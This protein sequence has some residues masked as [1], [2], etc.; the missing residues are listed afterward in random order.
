MEAVVES[1]GE[2]IGISAPG[3]NIAFLATRGIRHVPLP[4]STRGAS[5]RSD[6]RA[7]WDLRRILRN[8]KP[9]VLHT[10]NPKPGIYG[11]IVGRLSG[12]PIVVNTVH[13]LYATPDD[14]LLK[15]A[16]IYALEAIASRFSD[17]ELVQNPEDLQLITGLRIS[18]PSK[19]R[20]LGNGVDLT[21]FQAP[22][23][24]VRA[25]VRAELGLAPGDI[26]VGFVGRLVEEKGLVEL[27][28]AM[29]SLEKRFV[30]HVVGPTD[31]EKADSLPEDFITE[32]K[33]D[34]TRF[35][36]MRTDVE[37][38]Y[39]GFDIFVL[40]SHREGF[41]RTAMEAA[42]SALP[43]V[44][45][46]IRG[47]RQ[48]VEDGLNGLLVPIR[49]PARLAE[50]LRRLGGDPGLRT[51]MGKASRQKAVKSFDE[52]R[53]VDIV[54]DSYH[55]TARA[56]GIAWTDDLGPADLEIRSAVPSDVRFL[57][58]LHISNIGG[59]FLPAL[60]QRFVVLLYRALLSWPQA[61]VLVADDGHGPVGFV[62]GVTDTSKFY[63]Y[64][65]SRFGFR[66]FLA[67]APRLVS[68]RNLRRAIE[69]WSYRDN[70]TG[71]TAELLS[72]AVAPSVRK[73]GLAFR[74]GL[75]FLRDVE[76]LQ[77]KPVKVTVGHDNHAALATYRKLG[78]T[79]RGT[80]E[81]HAGQ[82]SAV[83]VR[84]PSR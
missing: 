38:L 5:L 10:H 49:D 7:A 61:A 37:D 35:L 64:F 36:G 52:K 67:A 21:R 40:P 70:E 17:V 25:R 60:G 9:D 41:P 20:L 76:S 45:T 48:V 83:L 54:L 62:A 78:F 81:V 3:P 77:E 43:I 84:E 29:R 1:G 26:A 31:P 2:A 33:R 12:V 24:E 39:A 13:G 11:R 71:A 46:D 56:K 68:P 66:A 73:R 50:A 55:R 28:Q 16:F 53:V 65:A 80:T 75:A 18:H 6:L 42:A 4:T 74:L 57:A 32:A 15:R 82:L 44:A 34:G 14:P 72:M 8:E 30:L 63:R 19:A 58:R 59:G 69:T 23:P 51:R 47:C 22:T 79:H 27:I